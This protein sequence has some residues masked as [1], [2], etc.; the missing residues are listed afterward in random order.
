MLSDGVMAI[1]ATL[2]VLDIASGVPQAER[3]GVLEAITDARFSYLGYLLSFTVIGL[4]WVSHHAMF[5]RLRAVDRPIVFSNLAL[6]CLV[7]FIPWPTG[8]LAEFIGRGGR[9]AAI[10]TAFYSAV[11]ALIGLVFVFQWWHL[12]RHPELL[13]V[14]V[15]PSAIRRALGL[16]A[17]GPAVYALTIPLAFVSPPLCLL[18]YVAISAYFAAGPSSRALAD[19]TVGRPHPPR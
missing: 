1:A 11:M 3:V 6:L 2:L 16:A 5:D 13:R 7:A 19:G 18:I 14:V 10:A 15:T 8:L 17:V 4:I 9:N 12:S